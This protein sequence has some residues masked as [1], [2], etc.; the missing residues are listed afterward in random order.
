MTEPQ[1]RAAAGSDRLRAAHAD[2]EQVIEE[3][4]AAF[5]HG[6]LTKAELDTRAG[7][8]L[9]AR[10]YADLA[11]LTADIPAAP[12]DLPAVAPAQ[13]P[14]PG[15]RRPL[16]RAAAGS[17]G[18]LITAAAAMKIAFKLDPGATPTP[19]DSWAKYFVLIAV[20]A[21]VVAVGIVVYGVGTWAGHRGS[22]GQLPP[23]PGPGGHASDSHA[24]DSERL[25]RTGH[26]PV[27]PGPRTGKNRADLRAL[28]PGASP[29][30]Q[31]APRSY[32]LLVS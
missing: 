2:R 19:Y 27:P 5:V 28:V 17:G 21:V 12:V 31:A 9:S 22:R 24:P 23:R 16:A 32:A 30:I 1:D 15:R 3:L 8:A 20:A 4:K 10:T 26:R 11:A 6:Q 18:C 7:Q 14:A 25:G 29:V 13:P